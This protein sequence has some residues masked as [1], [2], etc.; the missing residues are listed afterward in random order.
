MSIEF[1]YLPKRAMPATQ[2]FNA[3]FQQCGEF[4]SKKA[5]YRGSDLNIKQCQITVWTLGAI[6]LAGH[7]KIDG[8]FG[9]VDIGCYEYL[10]RG[11]VFDFHWNKNY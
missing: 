8:F 2:V 7:S 5:A 9:I 3:S 1:V 4:G 6:A 11:R 10:F